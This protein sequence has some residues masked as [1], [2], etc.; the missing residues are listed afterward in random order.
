MNDAGRAILSSRDRANDDPD[1]D[2][3][4]SRGR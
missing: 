1:S 4:T 3:E 2:R